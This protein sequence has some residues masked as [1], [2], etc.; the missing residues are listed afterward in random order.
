MTL[1]GG[2]EEVKVVEPVDRSKRKRMRKG[3]S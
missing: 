3:E 2:S 1:L